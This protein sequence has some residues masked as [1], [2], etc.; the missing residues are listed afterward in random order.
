MRM[1]R[2]DGYSR[3][4]TTGIDGMD[5][6]VTTLPFRMGAFRFAMALLARGGRPYIAVLAVLFTACAVLSFAA[7]MRW[8]IV[9]LMLVFTVSPMVLAFLY[10]SNALYPVTCTNT[11]LHNVA[12]TQDGLQISVMYAAGAK[13]EEERQGEGICSV[14]RVASGRV[15]SLEAGIDGI[16][17]NLSGGGKEFLWIPQDA[18][19]DK[20][21]FEK[22]VETAVSYLRQ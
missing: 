19:D 18:F 2:N 22:A 5:A 6:E 3:F 4:S 11:A 14:V 20:A 8:G 16:F 7:D 21:G 12:F 15:A 9:A 10:F 1:V 17:L 13:G